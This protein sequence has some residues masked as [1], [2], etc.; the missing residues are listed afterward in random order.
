MES[1]LTTL[2]DKELLKRLDNAAFI[3]RFEKSEDWKLFREACKHLADKADYMMLRIS[4]IDDPAGIIECQ[5]IS[6]FCKDMIRGI[7]NGIK[8]E[9]KIAFEEGKN[10]KLPLTGL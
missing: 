6:K 7:I 2:S 5:V 1:D 9:G 10:R 4:P 8:S 3:D